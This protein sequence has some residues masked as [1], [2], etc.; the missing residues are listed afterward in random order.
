[1]ASPETGT[2]AKTTPLSSDDPRELGSYTL[3]GKLG[4]GG[5]GTVY[6]GRSERG[7]LVAIKVIRADVADDREFRNRFR[8]EA[9]TARRVARVCTA[10]VLDADPEA[11]QPYLVTE[12]IEGKTLSKWVSQYGP[13][14]DANLEQLA[15]GMASALTAIHSAGIV[16]RDLKPS[17]VVLSPF[18]PRVIDFGIARALD[19]VTNLTG[20]M[21]QL[22]T[23]AFMSP[24]QI[25][26]G[27]ITPAADVF[28]W[29]GV[30]T[31]AA[32]G[33]FPFGDGNAQVL[34]YRALHEEPRLDGLDQALH[35]IVWH[36]MRK[37][38]ANRPSAQQLMLRLLG[39]SPTAPTEEVQAEA[40]QLLADWRLPAV[41][42][43]PPGGQTGPTSLVPNT[44]TSGPD[45]PTR[46][47]PGSTQQG[48]APPT[49]YPQ[50]VLGDPPPSKKRSRL[51]TGLVAACA[52]AIL[53][54]AGLVVPGLLS[55]DDEF[56]LPATAAPLSIDTVVYA[57]KRVDFHQIVSGR[58]GTDALTDTGQLT[59]DKVDRR[60]PEHEPD[61]PCHHARP[62][63]GDLLPRRARRLPWSPSLP[64]APGNPWNC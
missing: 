37:D 21:Q 17:N 16:H 46:I 49:P 29:G 25:E 31:F 8:L 11:E 14:A 18:G 56:V 22:G 35:P 44:R 5:M 60:H 32:T 9:E 6:L 45:D 12:F 43:N 59:D 47:N 27:T 48:G 7:R 36:A 30:V 34:L 55:G 61:H 2:T 63:D 24:E 28:A 26:G 4:Q 13:L 64:T 52:A 51:M 38:P 23:P 62:Q 58:I 1:M 41:S 42:T 57:S 53:I 15:V 19:A 10:E 20:D 3:L 54:A 33:R 40:T 39:E 50:T